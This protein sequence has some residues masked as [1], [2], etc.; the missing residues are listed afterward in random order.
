[1]SICL[2]QRLIKC[3]CCASIAQAAIIPHGIIEAWGPPASVSLS[4][5]DLPRSN[6]V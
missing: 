1:L 6:F 3:C 2:F 5:R 4:N